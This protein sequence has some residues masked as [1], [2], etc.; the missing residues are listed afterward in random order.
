MKRKIFA[1]AVSLALLSS[2]FVFA[3]PVSAGKGGSAENASENSPHFDFVIDMG[4]RTDIIDDDLYDYW[5]GTPIDVTDKNDVTRSLPGTVRFHG[6]ATYIYESDGTW[7]P[8]EIAMYMEITD[9]F[10]S[11]KRICDWTWT[12]TWDSGPYAGSWVAECQRILEFD[13][14]RPYDPDRPYRAKW[15]GGH[16][17]F[18]TTNDGTGYFENFHASFDLWE[19]EIGAMSIFGTGHFAP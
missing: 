4:L 9:N 12:F 11:G 6:N 17:H 8:G 1:V 19:E 3:A 2:L 15:I 16:A 14:W 18:T 5:K 13:F 10:Q 7:G